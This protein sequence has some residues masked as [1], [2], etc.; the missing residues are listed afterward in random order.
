MA[1]KKPDLRAQKERKQ[2]IVLAVGGVL[3]VGVL[4]LQGP[5]LLK[6]PSST[7]AT[8][9]PATTTP[10]VVTP[11]PVGSP[12]APP[13][14]ASASASRSAA[15]LAGV[16]LSPAKTPDAVQGQLWSFSRFKAKDPFVQ[17][18]NDGTPSGGTTTGT[19]TPA[20]PTSSGA[21]PGTPGTTG[22][23]GTP[24][25]PGG[26]TAPTV[27][28][29]PPTYA[30]LLV[31]GHPQ[32][33]ILKQLFPKADP[34]FVLVKIVGKNARIGVAGGSFTVGNTILLE[35]GKRVTLMNTTTGQR[36]VVKLVYV[37]DQPETIAVFKG[38]NAVPSATPTATQSTPTP[39]STP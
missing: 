11:A 4:A 24:D 30:T 13:A 31:N 9:A 35:I 14:P 6:H 38:G 16:V 3:L 15:R 10:G 19:S 20:A 32:Q 2:K 7:A 39:A 17:Q 36:Y 25:I 8:P 37:G 1:T 34:I 28:P 12:T 26:S 21:T 22:A 18:V 5:K 27:A 23:T 33:L 29:A